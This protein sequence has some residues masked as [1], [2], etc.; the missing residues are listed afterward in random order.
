MLGNPVFGNELRKTLVRR[1]PLFCFSFWAGG[2]V[3]LFWILAELPN[4]NAQIFSQFPHILLPIIAPAFAAGAFAKE[5]EQRTWTDLVLTRLTTREILFG[6]FFACYLPV[7]AVLFTVMPSLV[8][9]YY[10]NRI[11]SSGR[12]DAYTTA[13]GPIYYY[14]PGVIREDSPDIGPEIANLAQKCI[15][16]TAFYVTLAMVCSHY[17][18]KMRVALVVCYVSLAIYALAAILLIRSIDGDPSPRLFTLQNVS[19]T[20]HGAGELMHLAT[21]IILTIGFWILLAVGLRF[22]PE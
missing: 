3:A 11:S 1:K 10:L 9:G 13:S 7:L 6:K 22:D 5:R 17:C 16:N 14:P 18:R 21:S 8:M 19:A 12:P 20:A 15:L 4:L 2:Q